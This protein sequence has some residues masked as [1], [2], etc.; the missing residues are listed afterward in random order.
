M[1]IAEEEFI[2]NKIFCIVT[3]K[4]E[5]GLQ[6]IAYHTKTNKPLCGINIKYYKVWDLFD[7]THFC[8]KCS[9]IYNGLI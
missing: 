4:N 1:W 5:F 3:G 9:D 8:Q 7:S 2:E 6:H